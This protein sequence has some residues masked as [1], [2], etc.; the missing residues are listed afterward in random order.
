MPVR[1]AD[2]HADSDARPLFDELGRLEAAALPVM[3]LEEVDH[4][5]AVPSDRRLTAGAAAGNTEP[6]RLLVE[7]LAEAAQIAVVEGG[8]RQLETVD[9]ITHRPKNTTRAIRS[10][11]LLC[12]VAGQQQ[13]L[14][15]RRRHD[16]PIRVMTDVAGF[17][18]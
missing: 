11:V 3:L 17:R 7:Q 9:A 15:P 8:E 16:A 4:L 5:R 6:P 13:R 1:V 12:P 10:S 2:R 18:T 14:L